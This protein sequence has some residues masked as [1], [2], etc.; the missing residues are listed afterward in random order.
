MTPSI[1]A[2]F[3]SNASPYIRPISSLRRER[4]LA[5]NSMPSSIFCWDLAPNPFNPAIESSNAACLSVAIDSTPNSSFIILIRFGPKPG[6]PS[7]SIRPGGVLLCRSIQSLGH[8]PSETACEM[9][10]P[11]PLPMPLMSNIFPVATN[12]PRS[13]VIPPKVRLAF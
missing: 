11:R 8:L 5:N 12:S 9:A 4:N 10:E 3:C 7:I 1:P 2:I 13:S 6:I